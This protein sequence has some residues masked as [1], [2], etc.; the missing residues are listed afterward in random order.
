MYAD[1]RYR[2]YLQEWPKA[3]FQHDI[4]YVKYNDLTKRTQLNKVLRD[5]AFKITS[6]PEYDGYQK[7]LSSMVFN[8][9][10]Q[11]FER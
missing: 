2:L 4:A 3:F 10:W 8:F 7:G 11:T 1:R 9:F 5:K 6:N